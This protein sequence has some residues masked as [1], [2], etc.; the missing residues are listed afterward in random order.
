M[1]EVKLE[2]HE[3]MAL[4][5]KINADA[6]SIIDRL[7]RIDAVSIGMALND[8]EA[9][10]VSDAIDEARR[11]K[12]LIRRP[13]R[14]SKCRVCGR[15]RLQSSTNLAG[16]KGASRNILQIR[17]TTS[18]SHLSA[19]RGTQSSERVRIASID[20]YQS[21]WLRWVIWRLTSMCQGKHRNGDECATANVL[22]V[23]GRGTKMK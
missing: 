5:G 3:L 2:K 14:V 6:Q 20:S 12:M 9:S 23:D 17:V 10:L 18:Q 4:D 7:K 11:S 15:G 21:L 19:W 8:N 16:I 22:S 13:C 1:I